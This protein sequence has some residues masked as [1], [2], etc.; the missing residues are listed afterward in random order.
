[1]W[2]NTPW[3]WSWLWF[4]PTNRFL[5]WL[6]HGGSFHRLGALA[7]YHTP[8]AVKPVYTCRNCP[9]S[10]PACPFGTVP[11]HGPDNRP[12][13]LSK[14]L[15]NVP[16]VGRKDGWV[17]KSPKCIH[18]W[19]WDNGLKHVQVFSYHSHFPHKV[20]ILMNP[21]IKNHLCFWLHFEVCCT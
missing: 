3:D 8:N 6:S 1:M 20:K 17:R 11:G 9:G 16:K 10:W 5:F 14:P 19:I 4:R 12:V 13:G 15:C 2:N 7:V 18:G 21:E